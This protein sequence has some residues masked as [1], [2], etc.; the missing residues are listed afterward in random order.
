[1]IFLMSMKSKKTVSWNIKQSD[2]NYHTLYEQIADSM[3]EMIFDSETDDK[4][5][6]TEHE[7]MS[8][9]GVSRSVIREAL[10]LLKE[11]GL[12]SMRAGDGS[13]ATI[14][15]GEIIS[16]TLGRVMRFNGVSDEKITRVR[17]V[18]EAEAA[19][20]AALH[21]TEE[22]IAELE[23]IVRQ[24]EQDK[25]DQDSRINWD[26]EFHRVVARLS[27]N[28]LLDFMIQS[29]TELLKEYIKKRLIQNPAGNE[30]GIIGHRKIIKAIKEHHAGLAKKY[31][32]THIQ[33][34]SRQLD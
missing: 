7:L 11:R 21:A 16:R 13:Y 14:P 17:L 25:N 8:K 9:Y 10:K 20:E 6:P 29:I 26:C 2:I 24:M 3:E 33:L 34:S 15:K 31:M 1:M 19:G 30:E 12:V 18:L 27:R 22:D 23:G 5:L 28:E 32:L 4:R